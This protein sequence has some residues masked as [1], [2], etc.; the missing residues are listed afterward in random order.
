MSDKKNIS[1]RLAGRDDCKVIFKAL[2]LLA[3]SLGQAEN[4]KT[5]QK[6]LEEAGFGE[7]KKFTVTLAETSGTVAGICLHFPMFSTWLGTS[8]LYV[9]DVFIFEEHR[10][11]GIGEKLLREVAKWGREQGYHYIRLAVNIE[12][13]AGARFYERLGFQHADDEQNYTLISDRFNALAGG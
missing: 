7:N 10:N 1:F 6:I 3:C 11:A 13:E 9:Q 8:G 12:N 5:T 4:F 2:K